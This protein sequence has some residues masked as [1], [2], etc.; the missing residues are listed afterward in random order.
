MSIFMIW[1]HPHREPDRQGPTRALPTVHTGHRQPDRQG[2][3]GAL[4]TV[5]TE[6]TGNEGKGRLGTQ[7]TDNRTDSPTHPG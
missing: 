2:H 5:H 3:T 7:S 1:K 4:S 6:G